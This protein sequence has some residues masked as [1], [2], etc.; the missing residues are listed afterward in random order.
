MNCNQKSALIQS[1]SL[2]V[3]VDIAK[4]VHIAT[5]LDSKGKEIKKGIKIPN[6]Q[7]GF[8]TMKQLLEP[9]DPKTVIVSM[10]PTGHY[11][12]SLA[13]NL[14]KQGYTIALINPYHTKLSKE[15]GNNSRSK[16]DTKDSRLIARL[17]YEA[18][19]SKGILLEGAYAEV[20]KLSLLRGQIIQSRT[21][22]IIQLKTTLDEYL[23]EYDRIF[24]DITCPS[25][26]ELLQ[27]Y[28]L[29]GL[30]KDDYIS[31]KIALLVQVSRGQVSQDRAKLIVH[32]LTNSVGVDEGLDAADLG[33]Q[34]QLRQI[35]MYKENEKIVRSELE[36]LLP[37]LPET[38]Y[39]KDIPGVGTVVLSEI[40]GQTGSFDNYQNYKQIE[41]LAGLTPAHIM[42]GSYKGVTRINKRG[43]A[44]LRA[45]LQKLSISLITT[46]TAFTELYDY[47]VNVL[48]KPKM[49]A[50]ITLQVKIL[51]IMFSLVKNKVQYQEKLMQKLQ[52]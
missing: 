16:D 14:K 32:Q 10:E 23:P 40:L 46:N 18:K 34:L 44:Y 24:K 38:Q 25:S 12:K 11:Y 8:K 6:T 9:H 22:E 52:S 37:E 15:I 19:F 2:I 51:K 35:Q 27:T 30:I 33:L 31:E 45:A 4:K 39:L 49:M 20:R 3:G 36:R 17:T 43:S 21:R 47:K 7:E 41:K 42:S 29:K 28:G 5:A 1:A 50:L 26:F 48:K 13:Y